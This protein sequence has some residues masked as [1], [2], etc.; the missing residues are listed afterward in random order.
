[1]FPTYWS[2]IWH[3]S[4]FCLRAILT[5]AD[6]LWKQVGEDLALL[7]DDADV[8][9][10]FPGHWFKLKDGGTCVSIFLLATFLGPPPAPPKFS[11]AIRW[12]AAPAPKNTQN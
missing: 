3:P 6:V 9:G 5:A 10:D 4:L 11:G 2:V 1:M 8:S 12:H 7:D